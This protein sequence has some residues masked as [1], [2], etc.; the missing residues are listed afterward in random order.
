MLYN[1]SDLQS[2]YLTDG[3]KLDH[4]RQYPKGTTFVYSNLTARQS[5]VEGID[6]VVFFGLKYYIERYLIEQFNQWFSTPRSIAIDNYVSLIKEYLGPNALGGDFSHIEALYD[7][8]YLPIVIKS[9]PEGSK[10]DIGIPMLTIAHT[11]PDFFWLTNYLETSLS[12]TLWL[13]ITSA[14]TALYTRGILDRAYEG[15]DDNGWFKDWQCHDFSYRGM[16]SLESACISGAAHLLVFKGTDTIPAIPFIKKYYTPRGNEVIGGSVAATEHS[17]QCSYEDDEKYFNALIDAYPTGILSVV[18]D[19]YDFW[20]VIENILPKLKDKILSRDGKLVIRG[21]SGSPLHIICGNKDADNP[22]ER[23]GL[24]ECL[25][26]IFGGS[27]NSYGYKVLD[28]HIGAIYGDGITPERMKSILYFLSDKGFAPSNIVFGCGSFFYQYGVSRDTF[29]MAIKA[30]SV[31]INGERKAIFKDPKTSIGTNKKSARGLLR[32]DATTD[33][34]GFVL[35]ED[36]TE[37]EE[38]GGALKVV[39]KDGVY[40]NSYDNSLEA[41]RSRVMS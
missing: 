11:H 37:E 39:F 10:V 38:K 4:R 20:N 28:P 16:S 21:D 33:E 18:S 2:L 24:I 27:V 41:I 17:C 13:G 40:H 29:G 19:G 14:T 31:I 7:L 23:K 15:R 26:D 35:T 6:K 8:Q 32:V 25:W 5:R 36:V 30:T 3:Y 12:N 9:L 22:F 34:G 1:S